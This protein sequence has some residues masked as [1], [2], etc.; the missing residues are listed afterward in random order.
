MLKGS[1]PLKLARA[2][3]ALA[4]AKGAGGSVDAA[5]SEFEQAVK[6]F[7]RENRWQ[8]AATTSRAWAQTLRAA[9]RNQ[10]A[11]DVLDRAA[12]YAAR[13]PLVAAPR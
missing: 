7:V 9:G 12:E 11:L 4:E 2:H 13:V 8:E 3:A 1:D 10:D 6:L 5:H